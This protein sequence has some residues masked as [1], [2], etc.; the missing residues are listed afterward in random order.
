MKAE[1]CASFYSSLRESATTFTVE[2]FEVGKRSDLFCLLLLGT[3][4]ST[5]RLIL[6]AFEHTPLLND[7][8]EEFRNGTSFESQRV[9]KPTWLT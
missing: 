5:I 4:L 9:R 8:E 6:H 1:F 2:D 3:V 7:I